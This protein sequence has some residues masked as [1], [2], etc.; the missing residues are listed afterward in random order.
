MLLITLSCKK[1][2]EESSNIQH[3]IT[4]D[5]SERIELTRKIDTKEPTFFYNHCIKLNDGGEKCKGLGKKKNGKGGSFTLNEIEE[6]MEYLQNVQERQRETARTATNLGLSYF[7]IG[8]GSIAAGVVPAAMVYYVASITASGV[9]AYNNLRA[10]NRNY[11]I[12]ALNKEDVG[13]VLNQVG[14]SKIKY[15]LDLEIKRFQS[16]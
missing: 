1:N 5:N 10:I 12:Y 6:F 14:M 15:L 9:S 8:T 11:I 4:K 13:I 2:E 3:F 16:L 7:A